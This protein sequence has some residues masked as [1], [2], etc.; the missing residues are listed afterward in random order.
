M[1]QQQ[2]GDLLERA[3]E[4]LREH[5]STVVI[6]A[7]FMNDEPGDDDTMTCTYQG[8]L[9]NAVGAARYLTKWLDIKQDERIK[10]PEDLQ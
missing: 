2:R 7:A 1:T 6:A 8:G 3:R 10:D 4:L 5:C 9:H